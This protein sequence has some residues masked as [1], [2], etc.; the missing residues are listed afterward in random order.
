MADHIRILNDELYRT[1]DYDHPRSRSQ[2]EA[3]PFLQL[4]CSVAPHYRLDWGHGK[5]HLRGGSGDLTKHWRRMHW[6]FLSKQDKYVSRCKNTKHVS[7][8]GSYSTYSCLD[9]V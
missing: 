7:L 3:T 6:S 4:S 1:C 8:I 2:M 9:T 5:R